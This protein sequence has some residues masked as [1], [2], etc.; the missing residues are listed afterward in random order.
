M[1]STY[2]MQIVKRDTGE[3]VQWEPGRG[4]ETD[5]IAACVREILNAT[6][7][8]ADNVSSDL[9]S[10]A[11]EEVKAR[12]VAFRTTSHVLADVR[13]GFNAALVANGPEKS[14]RDLRAAFE[15][16]IEQGIETA[17]HDLK[18][19]VRPV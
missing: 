15:R 1:A 5:F 2:L 18:R 8:G 10:R 9:V 3:V 4:V 17:I 6:F 7:V 14:L 12:G 13:D 11:L 16:S 19:Q